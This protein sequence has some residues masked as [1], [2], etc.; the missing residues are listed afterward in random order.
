MILLLMLKMKLAFDNHI[1]LVFVEETE[2]PQEG[3]F[4]DT[5]MDTQ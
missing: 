1:Y 4:G 2:K 5:L 3:T